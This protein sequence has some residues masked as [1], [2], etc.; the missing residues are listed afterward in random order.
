MR[1]Y[2]QRDLIHSVPKRAKGFSPVLQLQGLEILLRSN[3]VLVMETSEPALVPEWLRTAGSVVGA[4]N[5]AQHCV[6]SSTNIAHH[7]RNRSSKTPSRSLYAPQVLE[8]V[9]GFTSLFIIIPQVVSLLSFS[10]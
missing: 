10:D 6:S 4:R 2:T 9:A 5:S 1:G 7:T 3:S 8:L